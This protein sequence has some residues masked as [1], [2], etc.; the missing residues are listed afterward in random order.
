M[1][2]TSERVMVAF[3]ANFQTAA[4]EAARALRM[5]QATG[6]EEDLE[7]V[8]NWLRHIYRTGGMLYQACGVKNNKPFYI[9]AVRTLHRR[10]G[11]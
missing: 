7:K 10:K 5:A 4:N 3:G 11:A 1:A 6:T 2:L 8:F 9:D